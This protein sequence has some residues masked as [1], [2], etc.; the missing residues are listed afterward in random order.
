MR[1]ASSVS[2]VRI[3]ADFRAWGTGRKALEMTEFLPT[4]K[5]LIAAELLTTPDVFRSSSNVLY[6]RFLLSIVN[7]EM[8]PAEYADSSTTAIK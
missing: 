4:L 7:D 6:G 8:R 3:T 2:Q 1:T 5:N